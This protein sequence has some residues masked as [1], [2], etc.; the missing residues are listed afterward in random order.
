MFDKFFLAF[1]LL[2]VSVPAISV[3]FFDANPYWLIGSLVFAVA[4]IRVLRKT[5]AAYVVT[6]LCLLSGIAFT[7]NLMLGTC[8]YMQGEGFNDAFFYHL[9]SETLV[10]AARTY[11]GVFYPSLLGLSLAVLAPAFF[12]KTPSQRIW[13]AIPVWL[14]W[15]LAVAGNYPIYSLI[16]YQLGLFA[17]PETL[18]VVGSEL[19][20]L[21]LGQSKTE[22][23]SLATVSENPDNQVAEGEDCPEDFEDTVGNLATAPTPAAEVPILPALNPLPETQPDAQKESVLEKNIILLYA[24]SIE[25]LYFEQE[26]FGDLLPNI[27]NLSATAH[28]FTNLVQVGG[29]GWTIAGI[30]AS[31][32]GF[33]LK[34]SSHL[35]SNSTIAS[36]N[37]P[38][39]DEVCLA[40]IL[41]GKGYET[42]FMGGAPLWFAGKGNFL[43]T[44]GYKRIAGEE[45]LT[46]LLPNK[47]HKSGWGLY[48]ESLFEL[49]LDELQSLENESQP[50]LLTL[51]SLDTHH[52]NGLPSKSCE[53]LP[54]N[55]DSMSNAIYCTDQVISSFISEA[56][57]MVDMEKTII[58][59]FSDHLS[60]RNTLW[61]K[62]KENRQKRRLTLMIF[63]DS[64]AIVSD[65]RGTHFDVAPTILEAAGITDHSMVGGG[66]SLFTHVE[67]ETN[68]NR[69]AQKER[70]VPSLL[71]PGVSAKES[72]VTIS[73][74]DLSLSFGD[75][76]LKAND[77]GQD[78]VSGMYLAVL[79]EEGN[80]VDAIYANDYQYLAKNL[81]GTFVIGIS[82]LPNRL[83]SAVYFYGRIT[84]DGR[85]ITQRVFD[86]DVNLSVTDLWTPK[87]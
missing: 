45:E 22:I 77:S 15:F 39:P 67:N 84:P 76:I 32:C 64:P 51:L 28:R 6:I 81:N 46:L 29:T 69:L 78:F 2:H 87:G 63:D 73:R 9:S 36:V 33:P 55:Q 83:D 42:V 38:Y 12:R 24:E 59:L 58:V 30:V 21:P 17:E 66:L 7:L 13:P 23:S 26:L 50:Y 49:A 75:L 54:N 20:G 85:D 31:Q 5:N 27:R 47:K 86:H 41:S 79:N 4:M 74:R 10:I 62:L 53:K 14:L 3:A 82:V 35:A 8:Y 40:D 18:S 34:V 16:S 1:A 71:Q 52:P 56:M 68:V 80:V 61:D 70:N 65:I 57:K 48:D 44:H 43:R 72:G 37:A 19:S 11:G 60:L 25:A